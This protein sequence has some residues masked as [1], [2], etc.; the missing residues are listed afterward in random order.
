M[1]SVG[2]CQWLDRL[3]YVVQC[4]QCK[5]FRIDLFANPM[6]FYVTAI[7]TIN[8]ILWIELV[9]LFPRNTS[10]TLSLWLDCRITRII[11]VST[12]CSRF[13]LTLIL[14]IDCVEKECDR[15]K[16]KKLQ[17]WLFTTILIVQIYLILFNL[18]R[19]S[20]HTFCSM[21]QG[22]DSLWFS[23]QHGFLKCIRYLHGILNK[24][25]SDR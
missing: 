9:I 24:W 13:I 20:W 2:R 23:K 8:L 25:T 21:V 19:L 18:I 6:I 7:V 14:N 17:E 10:N 1:E 5:I 15:L 12:F 22:G 4:I 11:I 16:A 3:L